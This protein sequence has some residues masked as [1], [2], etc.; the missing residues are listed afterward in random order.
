MNTTTDLDRRTAAEMLR[1]LSILAISE[2][3]EIFEAH[4]LV[5]TVEDGA[6][7]SRSYYV[8]GQHAFDHDPHH[9]AVVRASFVR[10]TL[11]DLEACE[12]NATEPTTTTV[13]IAAWSVEVGDR[14]VHDL[15]MGRSFYEEPAQP[16]TVTHRIIDV[17]GGAKRYRI[18]G[19]DD[20]GRDV[21]MCLPGLATVHL[22]Q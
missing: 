19:T 3:V 15:G 13:E 18:T 21:R 10:S 20:A 4:G 11:N 22:Y 1:T 7:G 8:N 5:V 12:M 16:F 9:T 17:T 14:V 2:A 6:D